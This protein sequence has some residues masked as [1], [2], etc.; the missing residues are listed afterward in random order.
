MSTK[1]LIKT[2][3]DHSVNEALAAIGAMLSDDAMDYIKE[4]GTEI[5]ALSAVEQKLVDK[6]KKLK[7]KINNSPEALQLA[8]L[9]AKLRQVSA[10]RS[11]NVTKVSG[12]I[13]QELGQKAD[14][15]MA[16]IFGDAPKQ[17]KTGA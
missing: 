5:G 11:E 3:P 10:K 16:V 17:L 6:A 12:V 9:K 1:E 8:T 15:A 7:E 13:E 14:D 2:G 4:K